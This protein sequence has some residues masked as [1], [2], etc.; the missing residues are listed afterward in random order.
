MALTE[1]IPDAALPMVLA[2]RRLVP[3]RETL[4]VLHRMPNSGKSY[5]RWIL[6]GWEGRRMQHCPMGFL[7]GAEV[8][9]PSCFAHLAVRDESGVLLGNLEI[10]D[11]WV[12]WDTQTD[13]A[14]AV[15]AVWGTE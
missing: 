10:H 5:L 13:A 7:P 6:P 9:S 12:W 3:R 11:F 4:P 15:D 8:P 14:A 1:R 2:I